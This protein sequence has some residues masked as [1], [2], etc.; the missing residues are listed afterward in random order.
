MNIN[1]FSHSASTS[2][3]QVTSKYFSNEAVQ[4]ESL[5]EFQEKRKIVGPKNP[6]KKESKRKCQKRIKG[7][8]DIRTLIKKKNDLIEYSKNFNNICKKSGVDIDSEQL[9]LAIAL[10]KSLHDSKQCPNETDV[11]KTLTS[12][13]QCNKIR[14]TLKEYGFQVPE[15]KATNLN[16]IK[17][18]RYNLLTTSDEEKQQIISA[19]YLQILSSKS[20]NVIIES[21]L[22]KESIFYKSTCMLF[23]EMRN[24]DVFYVN[25]LVE[26]SLNTIFFLRDWSDIPGRCQS[27]AFEGPYIGFNDIICS[28]DELNILLS[29]CIAMAQNI[30][31]VK[32]RNYSFQTEILCHNTSQGSVEQAM[33]SKILSNE[34]LSLS[35]SEKINNLQH[36]TDIEILNNDNEKNYI[37]NETLSQPLSMVTECID[38][39]TDLYRKSVAF[40]KSL[41]ETTVSHYRCKSPDLFDEE[42]STILNMS[43]ELSKP[44]VKYDTIDLTQC[45]P[46]NMK[47]QISNVSKRLSNDVMELTECIAG[48]LNCEDRID[49]TQELNDDDTIVYVDE[50]VNFRK[51]MGSSKKF[52]CDQ[53][54]VL[55]EINT[56]SIVPDSVADVIKENIQTIDTMNLTESSE[57]GDSLPDINVVGV[58]KKG[59]IKNINDTLYDKLETE[60]PNFTSRDNER[61]IQ[62]N[63]TNDNIHLTQS[64]E[65]NDCSVNSDLSK[66]YN[67]GKIDNLSVDYDD[68]FDQIIKNSTNVS[69]STNNSKKYITQNKNSSFS[70]SEEPASDSESCRLSD[71]ELNYSVNIG[72]DNSKNNFE[73]LPSIDM[74]C[75]KNSVECNIL[76]PVKEKNF[77]I[78]KTPSNNE[79][80]IKTVDV[81]PMQNFEAMSSPERNKELEKYGLKPFKRK[82]AIQLL[83]YIYNQTHPVVESCEDGSPT[84]KPKLNS[85]QKITGNLSQSP[86]KSQKS[87]RKTNF[88][89]KKS[90]AASQDL[91]DEENI[92]IQTDDTPAIKNIACEPEDWV[93]QKREKAKVHSCRVPLHVAFHNYVSCRRLLREAILCYEPINID[94]VHKDLVAAGYRYNPKDL[95]K[96]MDKKCITVKTADNK[97]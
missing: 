80:I 81:T 55:D 1:N 57:S 95:L 91:G 47:P 70:N 93:F 78:I 60:V 5:T 37:V 35:M 20:N 83:T 51:T 68:M 30:C 23:E 62:D 27:P 43:S 96:F 41:N 89:V 49:L 92:F 63:S 10:S 53:I 71:Q 77:E 61:N 31:H 33:S 19:K 39:E 75:Q 32:L 48:G 44:E 38:S 7:Q 82:R 94:I 76:T 58:D 85:P 14:T 72:I 67:L 28:Q 74:N 34:T 25:G 40:S 69:E 84:K 54:M 52:E 26:K 21:N 59:T 3:T 8:K 88:S 66:M 15:V 90:P 6:Q 4:D 11:T 18:K 65:Y 64:K 2:K 29:G 13:E 22:Q 97:R 24:D 45:V 56:V 12:R 42:V 86:R 50:N 46:S 87:P 73:D 36:N 16:K 17:R 9:Q 79:Y